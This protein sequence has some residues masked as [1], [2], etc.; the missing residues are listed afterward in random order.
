MTFCPSG[1]LATGAEGKAL[2]VNE[3]ACTGC[4]LCERLCPDLAIVVTKQKVSV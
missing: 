2:A 4:G 1:T 3:D